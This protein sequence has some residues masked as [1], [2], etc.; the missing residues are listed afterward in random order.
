MLKISGI[1][2]IAFLILIVS[3]GGD[4]SGNS[5]ITIDFN[6][7]KNTGSGGTAEISRVSTIPSDV[8]TV[9]IRVYNGGSSEVYYEKSFAA[10][11]IASSSSVTIEVSPGGN[12][13]V[14]VIG[15]SVS[16]LARYSVRSDPID[17]H[18]GE[19]VEVFL[20]M[21][22]VSQDALVPVKLVSEDGS[23]AGYSVPPYAASIKAEVYIPASISGEVELGSALSGNYSG[24]LTSFNLSAYP[25]T[26]Q[27]IM[28]RVMTVDSDIVAPDGVIAAIGS[29]I[30]SELESGTN[31]QIVIRMVKPGRLNVTN[32]SGASIT[33]YSVIETIKG[34][35]FMI[36]S[37]SSLTGIGPTILLTVPNG[38]PIWGS[39]YDIA[40]NPDGV[41]AISRT[42]KIIING[43]IQRTFLFDGTTYPY[44]RWNRMDLNY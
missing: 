38:V 28:V 29:A 39:A 44:L 34:S 17:L 33:S 25:D 6:S 22:P 37:G 30:V 4:P 15:R 27:M 11:D 23:G 12:R 19:T 35:D 20:V 26:F 8:V 40:T 5:K 24:G 21:K 2:A 1:P 32:S 9:D 7:S 42:V 18:D 16:G 3:C 43:G 13:V 36:S 41:K 10:S 14:K 31:Q